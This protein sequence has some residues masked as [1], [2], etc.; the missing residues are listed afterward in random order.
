[1]RVE[2]VNL[3]TVDFNL[4]LEVRNWRNAEHVAKYFQ[5]PYI[6]EETHKNWLNSLN[7]KSPKNIA[8]LIKVDDKFVGLVY[9]LKVDYINLT[10]EW[11]V[12]MKDENYQKG[13]G[14]YV[15]YRMHEIAFN[16]L[17]LLKLNISVLENNPLV[18]QMHQKF[19]Y[20]NE[21]VLRKNIIK[22]KARL[23]VFLLGLFNYEWIASRNNFV[24]IIKRY[25][26]SN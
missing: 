13:V 2:L 10:G 24:N 26:S 5:I 6:D 4:Q 19:G 3:K 8:F 14:V 16:E 9:F 20:T 17:K 18:I 25:E 22:N 15:E 23:D 7:E 11:G 12:F 21:G 1:M